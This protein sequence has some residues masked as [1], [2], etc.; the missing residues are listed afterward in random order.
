[1]NI[2]NRPSAFLTFREFARE[3]QISESGVRKHVREGRL[4]K[5]R[6]GRS[7]RIPRS[8]LDRLVAQS[9]TATR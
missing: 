9:E 4:R 5:I 8:E 7:V 6:L 2:I 1:M 3:A